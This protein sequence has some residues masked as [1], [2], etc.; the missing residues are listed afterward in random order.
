MNRKQKNEKENIYE[1]GL[2]HLIFQIT[3]KA[4]VNKNIKTIVL[5]RMLA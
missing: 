1:K 2:D 5:R 3:D 4:R